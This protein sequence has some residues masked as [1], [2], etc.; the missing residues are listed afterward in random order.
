MELGVATVMEPLAASLNVQ[1]LCLQYT[2]EN[3][4]QTIK[5]LAKTLIIV[6]FSL[7]FANAIV[8]KLN[9]NNLRSNFQA[10]Y[11]STAEKSRI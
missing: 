9:C 8:Y 2:F 10:H 6:S 4:P 5:E 1:V 3:P 7:Q 11:K